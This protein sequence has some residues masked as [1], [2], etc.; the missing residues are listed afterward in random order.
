MTQITW[1]DFAAP[2]SGRTSTSREAAE[3][4]ADTVDARRATVLALI[5]EKADAGDIGLTA[6]EIGVMRPQYAQSGITARLWELRRAGLIRVVQDYTRLT[7]RGRR[8]R[9][10]TI[11]PA[12][13]AWLRLEDTLP[14]GVK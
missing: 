9:V 5:K 14:G 10:Y 4:V 12:G 3:S 13:Q 11:T 7:R 8:A 6:D 1:I 2:P